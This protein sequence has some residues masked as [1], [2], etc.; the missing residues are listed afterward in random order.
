MKARVLVL[1]LLVLASSI[2]AGAS[3]SHN[4]RHRNPH[5]GSPSH[6][7]GTLYWDDIRN[8]WSV[9]KW[10]SCRYVV[11][12]FVDGTIPSD[13][14]TP[15]VSAVGRW[16]R[17]TYCGPD[18]VRTTS[19][20]SAKL[21]FTSASTLCGSSGTK[22][23]AFACR[24]Y[25]SSPS[26]QA[27]TIAFSSYKRFGTGLSG[28]F[29]VESIAANEMG[30]VMYVDHNPEWSNG[31]TQGN[32]CTWGST[33]C[34]VTADTVAGF[35]PYTVTCANC[36]SRRALLAGDLNTVSH[37]Y[38]LSGCTTPPC[39]MLATTNR[40]GEPPGVALQP[41]RD[42]LRAQADALL[43]TADPDDYDTHPH[44]DTMPEGNH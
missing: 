25:A 9:Y 5:M 37:I 18:W 1:L 28:T 15:I 16:D 3:A 12:Y 41:S 19:S 32:S 2:P 11:N 31:I 8:G 40:D 6:D 27:W 30:H 10:P 14:L 29:D 13:W 7:A 20:S 21:R 4:P 34:L 43:P 17:P 33:S 36:G 39:P 38:G 22:W 42:A 24:T 44:L 35:V 26:N 23:I